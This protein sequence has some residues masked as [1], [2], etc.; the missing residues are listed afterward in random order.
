MKYLG[1]GGFHQNAIRELE[2]MRRSY[3]H[4][5]YAI[6]LALIW[7]HQ[8]AEL[9]DEDE[10]QKLDVALG[11]TKSCMHIDGALLA[12]DFYVHAGDHEAAS[13]CLNHPIVLK[14]KNSS[15]SSSSSSNS[16]ST[17]TKL[18]REANV[19]RCRIQLWVIL[20]FDLSKSH[21][22]VPFVS[23]LEKNVNHVEN[24]DS[25]MVRSR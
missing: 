10:L 3:R 6:V 5:E 17:T 4:L 21:A 19:E 12:A 9:V 18:V 23:A 13:A 15:N 22:D 24:I 7:F 20:I 16:N 8:K 1:F 2:S 11:A 14:V 25:T